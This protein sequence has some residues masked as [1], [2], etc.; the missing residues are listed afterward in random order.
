MES[1]GQCMMPLGINIA[2][3]CIQG[4]IQDFITEGGGPKMKIISVGGATSLTDKGWGSPNN[5]FSHVIELP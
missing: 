5:S 3:Q 4:W 1:G 2:I